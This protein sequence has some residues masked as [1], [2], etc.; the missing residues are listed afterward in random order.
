MARRFR[1]GLSL[2]P[3]LAANARHFNDAFPPRRLAENEFSSVSPSAL[4]LRRKRRRLPTKQAAD[5]ERQRL[6]A[7]AGDE[8]RTHDVR[9]GKA[10][11]YH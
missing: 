5:D 11:L 8:S 6:V 10:M 1:V 9:L 2:G 7:R 4:I 3:I